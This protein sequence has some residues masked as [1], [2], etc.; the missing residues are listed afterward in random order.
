MKYCHEDSDGIWGKS[1]LLAVVRMISKWELF[2]ELE[3]TDW[4]DEML[5]NTDE[6]LQMYER[7]FG[8]QAIEFEIDKKNGI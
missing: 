4:I 7:S 1:K 8:K 6:I 3:N 2:K 5:V